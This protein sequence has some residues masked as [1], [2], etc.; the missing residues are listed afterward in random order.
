MAEKCWGE[1]GIILNDLERG[2]VVEVTHFYGT[3]NANSKWRGK[4]NIVQHMRFMLGT[5]KRL[6]EILAGNTVIQ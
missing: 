2:K 5:V 3:W 4:V 1:W 6:G